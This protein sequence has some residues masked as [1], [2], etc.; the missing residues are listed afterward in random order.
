MSSQ[1]KWGLTDFEMDKI[2]SGGPLGKRMT[3]NQIG[4]LLLDQPQ[5]EVSSRDCCY[6]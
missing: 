1:A 2:R 5:P 4:E 6:H 3:L